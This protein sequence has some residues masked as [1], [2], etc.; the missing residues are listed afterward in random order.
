[1]TFNA[2]KVF[3]AT[4]Q[5]ERQKLGEAVT[6]WLAD[7]GDRITIVDHVVRQSSDE[8]HHCLSILLFYQQ[9]VS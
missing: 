4:K 7:Q 3:S 9:Q 8:S 2:V 6:N 1:M 5:E